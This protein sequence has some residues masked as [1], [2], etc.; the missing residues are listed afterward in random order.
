[1]SEPTLTHHNHP[2]SIVTSGFTP[3]VVHNMDFDKCVIN[4]MYPLLQYDTE[5]YHCP[6]NLLCSFTSIFMITS[7]SNSLHLLIPSLH[8]KLFSHFYLTGSFFSFNLPHLLPKV[9]IHKDLLHITYLTK[10]LGENIFLIRVKAQSQ[11]LQLLA[12]RVVLATLSP[13]VRHWSLYIYR[14]SLTQSQPLILER[15][16]PPMNMWQEIHP[17]LHVWIS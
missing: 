13:M 11:I 6:R 10:N 12:T 17:E 8:F 5:W 15:K 16:N 14:R 1:M 7:G 2:N 3:G 9:N 4:D